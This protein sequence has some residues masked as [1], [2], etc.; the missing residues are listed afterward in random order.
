MIGAWSEEHFDFSGYVR[1][2][3]PWR[4]PTATSCAPELGTRPAS[5]CASSPSAARGWGAA[6]L[7]RVMEASR[8]VKR[9]T[10]D[11]R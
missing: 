4:S 11:L 8:S 6:L 2:Y 7:R 9:R 5:G 10:P 3:D 1:G